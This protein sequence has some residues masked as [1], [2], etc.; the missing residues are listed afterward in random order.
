MIHFK[1]FSFLNRLKKAIKDPPVFVNN[2][3]DVMDL[4]MKTPTPQSQP[5]VKASSVGVGSGDGLYAPVCGLKEGELV[6]L[7]PGCVWP[8]LPSYAVNINDVIPRYVLAPT[9]SELKNDY[10]LSSPLGDLFNGVDH[11]FSSDKH[12]DTDTGINDD[13]KYIKRIR[14]LALGHKI[15]HPPLNKSPNVIAKHFRWLDVLNTLQSSNSNDT[16][17]SDYSDDA[18]RDRYRTRAKSEGEGEGEG[19]GENMNSIREWASAAIAINP[20]GTGDWFFDNDEGK[21]IPFP[22]INRST[23]V[24]VDRDYHYY[25]VE[26]L[27]LM[28]GAVMTCLCDVEPGEELFFD[29]AMSPKDAHDRDWYNPVMY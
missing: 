16:T 14:D 1:T 29:Y 27:Q 28:A 7:Y 9:R 21:M 26:Y 18:K 6:V 10:L 19:E 2:P 15:Q 3:K 11:S 12:T 13:N 17:I 25:N 4:L 20:L 23:T 5:Q 22:N 8:P 24:I